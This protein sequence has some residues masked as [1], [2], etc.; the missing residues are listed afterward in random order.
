MPSTFTTE[1][2]ALEQIADGEK[3]NTWG[4]TQRA[5]QVSLSKAIGGYLAK[6]VAGA[7]NVTLT[8]AESAGNRT[9][10]IYAGALGY[11]YNEELLKEKGLP[12]PQ[13]WRDR[14]SR[15]HRPLSARAPCAMPPG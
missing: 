4:A 7:S 3:D 13:C 11:G 5:D 1:L 10:G 12:V 8:Q 2:L 6:S 9:I 14:R 15:P